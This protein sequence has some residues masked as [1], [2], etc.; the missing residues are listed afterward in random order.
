M[1]TF[2]KRPE[3]LLRL[4]FHKDR[5]RQV[6]K[7]KK[8]CAARKLPY[9]EVDEASL[10]KVAASV[11]HEGLVMVVRPLTLPSIHSL[12]DKGLPAG[13]FA[14]ALD[15]VDNTHNVGAI[16]RSCAFFGA[17]GLLTETAQS[18]LTSS[19]ART[20]EGALE[21]VPIYPCKSLASALRDLQSKKVFVVGADLNAKKS[22]Y[23]IKIPF[24]CVVVAG[25]ERDGLSAPV[26]K[27][28]DVLVKIPGAGAMESLN[29]SVSVGV[30]LGELARR[31]TLPTRK[32]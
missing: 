25:N 20:A 30:L 12:V 13:S 11:H 7:I 5:S 17:A 8:W 21:L 10:N 16:L 18:V 1:Q 32:K 2:E 26:K 6:M 23:E 27:R 9:R 14:V 31:Q 22:L 28:C 24:P 19:M 3:E 4:F 15:R 29:V